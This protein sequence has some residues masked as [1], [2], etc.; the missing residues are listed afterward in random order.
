MSTIFDNLEIIIVGNKRKKI[1]TT[2]FLKD[3]P[4]RIF[5]TTDYDLPKDFKVKTQFLKYESACDHA[6]GAYRCFRGHQDAI[7]SCTKENILV[8]ED[9]VVPNNN[10]WLDIISLSFD[11]LNKFQIV[12]FHGRGFD[13]NKFDSYIFNDLSFL[14][15][16][17]YIPF[18]ESYILGSPLSYIIRKSNI[19]KLIN[20]EYVGN[21][22]DLYIANEFDF[23]VLEKSPFDHDR[24][25]GSLIDI[26]VLPPKI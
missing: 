13:K 20:D 9:D 11:V 6:L 17:S 1:I 25:M 21:P 2:D 5:Y 24:K 10:S 26:D 19:S 16:K 4:H 18:N 15:K 14:Y 12:S 3:I 23:C 22:Y 7:K 8:F